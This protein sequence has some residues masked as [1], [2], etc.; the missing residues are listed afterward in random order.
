MD[1]SAPTTAIRAEGSRLL[2]IELIHKWSIHTY[3]DF[4]LI[5]NDHEF[6]QTTVP[7][8]AFGH[9]YLLEAILSISALHVAVTT[10]PERSSLYH[11][12]A[13]EYQNRA[14]ANF[15]AKALPVQSSNHQA[16]FAFSLVVLVLAFAIPRHSP[17][18]QSNR[19]MFTNL[20]TVFSLLQGTTS[21]FRSS[22]AWLQTNPFAEIVTKYRGM[23][24]SYVGEDATSE[25]F[26]QLRVLSDAEYV[27]WCTTASGSLS[28]MVIWHETN[29]KAIDWLQKCFH[30]DAGEETLSCLA[31]IATLEP[32]FMLSVERAEPFA[33]LVTM[34]WAILLHHCGE[35][36]WWARS[37][38]K[39]LIT[40]L[41]L[42][43]TSR[44]AAWS[45]QIAW[46]CHQVGLPVIA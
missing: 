46:V 23:D 19:S 44:R 37:S 1:T 43:L 7:Q 45:S 11:R 30:A 39:I 38:G 36:R 18:D 35:N 25:A 33:L 5:A 16:L 32:E 9:D 8:D 20:K 2:E 28:D 27:S 24:P 4:H 42:A 41:C 17:Q 15:K 3:R 31:W 14:I 29:L 6:W 26:R 21:I 22:M 40:E 12:A 34:H 10:A 13:L